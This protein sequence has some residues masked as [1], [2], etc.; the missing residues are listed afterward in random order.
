M[1]RPR[2]VLKYRMG[3]KNYS[4][5]YTFNVVITWL[6]TAVSCGWLSLL[7]SSQH[8]SQRLSNTST[9]S[10]T[11]VR[12]L[13]IN[14]TLHAGRPPT[15]YNCTPAGYGFAVVCRFWVII[16][17][18]NGRCRLQQDKVDSWHKSD[19]RWPLGDVVCSSN[20]LGDL[21]QWPRHDNSTP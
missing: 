16:I 19:S 14:T 5:L 8:A 17:N 11:A 9:A 12:N 18:G 10:Q 2:Q 4:L 7:I 13:S 3:V 20:T 15:Y 21:S 6:Q 1:V